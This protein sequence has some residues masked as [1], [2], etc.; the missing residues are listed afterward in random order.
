MYKNFLIK[1][2]QEK[3]FFLY[4]LLGI[5]FLY[6]YITNHELLTTSIFLFSLFQAPQGKTIDQLKNEQYVNYQDKYRENLRQEIDDT[7]L[8]AKNNREEDSFVNEK[9]KGRSVRKII[10]QGQS[11]KK[12]VDGIKSRARLARLLSVAIYPLGGLFLLQFIFAL[13]SI[14]GLA[15]VGAV[16]SVPIVGGWLLS[17]VD[18]LSARVTGSEF[19]G[20]FG[21][22]LL[23]AA[24]FG[25]LQLAVLLLIFYVSKSKA[26][27][28]EF[29][30]LKWTAFILAATL[31][32]FPIANLFPL[33]ALWIILVFLFPK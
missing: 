22:F 27:G 10:T 4:S 11:I 13:I 9:E 17:G 25:W 33:G 24:F 19:S 20:L 31:Y 21:V 30:E 15:A 26:L 32:A 3:R 28:G 12:S 23:L 1:I 14:T 29:L 6:V 18:W 16:E 7:K 2:T 8:N 5:F